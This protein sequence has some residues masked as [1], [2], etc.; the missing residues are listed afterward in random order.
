[1]TSSGYMGAVSIASGMT[2]ISQHI[3]CGN[4]EGWHSDNIDAVHVP[5]VTPQLR[6]S[7]ILLILLSLGSS[8]DWGEGEAAGRERLPR[9]I[10]RHFDLFG[11]FEP[12]RPDL[13]AQAEAS[14]AS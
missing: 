4:V 7:V 11:L 12:E 10:Q 14:V 8:I 13:S 9:N 5:S 6:P 1:M 3:V 2:C